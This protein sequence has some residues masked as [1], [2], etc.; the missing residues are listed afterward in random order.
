MF[1]VRKNETNI[2]DQRLLEMK[3]LDLDSNLKIVRLCLKDLSENARLTDDKR[4][5][6]F[7]FKQKQ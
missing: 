3:C 7:I 1:L 5:L 6:M 4:L 2:G